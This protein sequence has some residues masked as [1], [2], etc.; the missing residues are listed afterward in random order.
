VI[1][2]LEDEELMY[3][4]KLTQARKQCYPLARAKVTMFVRSWLPAWRR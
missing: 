3:E 4:T 1:F 2:G